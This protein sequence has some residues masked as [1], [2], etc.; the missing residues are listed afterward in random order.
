[1]ILLLSFTSSTFIFL[2]N[3]DE[4][5]GLVF[6]RR[7]SN[8]SAISSGFY[9][10][11]RPC[12]P[13]D[14]FRF[15][16]FLRV[17]LGLTVKRKSGTHGNIYIY[18]NGNADLTCRNT[19]LRRELSTRKLSAWNRNARSFRAYGYTRKPTAAALLIRST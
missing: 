11:G 6:A 5:N 14:F 4:K 7:C 1:L 3:N 10:R 9:S 13:R 19:M 18:E 15:F 2:G 17:G 16:F 8:T 12:P